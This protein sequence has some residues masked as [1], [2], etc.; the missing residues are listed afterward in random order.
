VDVILGCVRGIVG[1]PLHHGERAALEGNEVEE[2]A[3]MLER[4]A[5][6]NLDQMSGSCAVFED[7]LLDLYWSV[8]RAD[9]EARGLW[10]GVAHA[11]DH[12]AKI[13]FVVF[14]R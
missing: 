3:T 13:V 7:P 8:R 10:H 4:D 1:G 9:Q 12:G 2:S 11:F 5:M 14:Q 6:L